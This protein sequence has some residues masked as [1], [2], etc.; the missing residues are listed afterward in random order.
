M[1]LSVGGLL[2]EYEVD[3]SADQQRTNDLCD[4]LQ[5]SWIGWEYKSFAG[6]L[7]N[8]TWCVIRVMS[9]ISVICPMSVMSEP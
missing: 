5:I 8:G 6:S 3:G 7:P 1:K 9:V 4:E 2:T